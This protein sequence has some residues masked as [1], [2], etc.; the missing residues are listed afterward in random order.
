MGDTRFLMDPMYQK[1]G[2]FLPVPS[3]FNFR[4]NPIKEFPGPPPEV[5]DRDILLITH[6]HF[7]HFD[8]IASK[9]IDKQIRVVTPWNGVKRLR[10]R[11]FVN[12]LSL[13]PGES[14]IVDNIEIEA[15]PVRHSERFPG[16][17]YKPGMGYLLKAPE[18]TVYIS[19]DTVLFDGLYEHLMNSKIHLAILYGGGARIPFLGRHTF[20]H[21]EVLQLQQA[22]QPDLTVVTHLDC[23]NHCREKSRELKAR[24]E[25]LPGDGELR[26][27]EPEVSYR[28]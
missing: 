8:K 27:P 14:I 2:R 12:I 19:G 22:I 10:R 21:D 16:L 17:L 11:G 24:I 7:D 20:S 26:V 9:K 28:F 4:W 15:T 6:H 25:K 18:K 3:S 23:L 1:K 5:T 13:R